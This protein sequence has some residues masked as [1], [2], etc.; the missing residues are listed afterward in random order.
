MKKIIYT[1]ILALTGQLAIAQKNITLTIK[2]NKVSCTGVG[3]ME[4]YQVRYGKSKQWEYF[5]NAIK[6]F[7]YEPGYR[8]KILVTETPRP[9]PM[10]A[11]ASSVTYTFK[12][13][14]LKKWMGAKK[15]YTIQNSF[16]DQKM[17]LTE[18]NG[19]SV[20]NPNAYLTINTKN[21]TIFGKSACNTF[22]MSYQ[23]AENNAMLTTGQAAG[24]M[25][26]CDEQTMKLEQDFLDAL[27]KKDFTIKRNGNTVSFFNTA[28]NQAILVF[29]IPTQEDIWAAINQKHWKLVQLD[30]VGQDYGKTYIAFD[31][32]SGRVSGNGGCNNFSGTY[33]AKKESIK[34][35]QLAATAMGCLDAKTG[36]SEHTIFQ[37]MAL[38]DLRYE[39]SGQTLT[40]YQGQK[41]LMVF[42][43]DTSNQ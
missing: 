3:Q 19:N 38:Q 31:V 12:K 27:N 7:S 21:K 8:Y 32:A 43:A 29:H 22:R 6:G 41:R 36:Q 11:D 17:I 9:K 40:F 33:I 16:Y 26:A 24:T 20:N 18:L 34:F 2:E 10:P 37:Y 25:M 15:V 28:S 13:L 5:H 35:S 23:T 42:A 30:N 14:L 39:L 1:L 4:C